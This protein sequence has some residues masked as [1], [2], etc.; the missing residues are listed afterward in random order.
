M[1]T[2]ISKVGLVIADYKD[3]DGLVTALAAELRR[4]G[5]TLQSWNVG[6]DDFIVTVAARR[7]SRA[8]CASLLDME[9]SDVV[10]R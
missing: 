7:L 10:E 4:F 3:G 9:Q 6:S 5:V 2:R 1:T 8:Q